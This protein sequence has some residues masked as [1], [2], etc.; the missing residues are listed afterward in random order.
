M[1]V[2]LIYYPTG[3]KSVLYVSDGME[4]PSNTGTYL[5]SSI[6]GLQYALRCAPFCNTSWFPLVQHGVEKKKNA[7]TLIY[8][9]EEFEI[10]TDCV[11]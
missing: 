3:G 5:C 2:C 11:Y 4:V 9:M 1:S 8:F 10:S 6:E 7:L